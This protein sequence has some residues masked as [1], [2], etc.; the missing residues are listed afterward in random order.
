M[1][2]SSFVAWCYYLL[3]AAGLFAFWWRITRD[4]S[5]TKLQRSLR[6]AVAALLVCPFSIGDGYADMAPAILMVAMETVFE[7]V[8][9]FFRGGPT[10]LASAALAIVGAL[11]WDEYLRRRSQQDLEQAAL[12]RDRNELLAESE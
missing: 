11:L 2:D 10:L 6:A 3:G 1:L 5:M 12:D 8:E 9:S 4:I 7:G